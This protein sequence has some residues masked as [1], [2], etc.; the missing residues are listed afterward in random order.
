MWPFMV[1]I[2]LAVILG[3]ALQEAAHPVAY[4]RLTDDGES[5][6][7]GRGPARTPGASDN[8]AGLQD[9][10]EGR[11][12]G[13][14]GIRTASPP[15]SDTCDDLTVLVDRKNHLPPDYVPP[16]LVSVEARGVPVFGDGMMLRRGAADHLGRMV[17]A[18]N[19]AGEQ[20]LVSSAYRSYAKQRTTFQRLTSIY[21]KERAKWTSAPPGQSQHQLGTAV[22]F[23]NSAVGYEIQKSFGYTKAS[24]WLVKHAPEYGFVLSYPNHKEAETGY[25]WEPWHYRYVG[26]ENATHMRESG[27]TLQE[28]LTREGVKPQCK[29]K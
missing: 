21:G 9:I 8:G 24:A 12:F 14:P 22:D 1:L 10:V 23:T 18:A 7:E 2:V 3:Y 13:A 16:N 28:F 5:P 11:K 19:A 15:P 27:S 25:H 6:K 26:T 4:A 17:R 20:I 29:T